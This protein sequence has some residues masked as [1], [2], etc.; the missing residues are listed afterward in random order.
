[1]KELYSSR[2][3]TIN[4]DPLNKGMLEIRVIESGNFQIETFQDLVEVPP[5]Q[6]K[7]IVK[8]VNNGFKKK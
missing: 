4:E 7:E 8:A 3:S 6:M 1:M 2:Q 5:A